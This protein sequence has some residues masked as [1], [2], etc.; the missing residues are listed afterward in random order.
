[1]ADPKTKVNGSQIMADSKTKAVNGN[2]ILTDPKPK[3]VNGN[4]TMADPKAKAVNGGS[5]KPANGNDVSDK[6][7]QSK[8][9]QMLALAK[10]VAKDMET[11]QDF[12]KAVEDRKALE[13]EIEARTGEV[14]TLREF[15]DKILREYSEYKAE[16]SSK[17]DTLLAAFEQRYK[18]YDSNNAAVE[19][20]EKQVEELK[21]KLSAAEVSEKS[22]QEQAGKLQQRVQ[23][24][25][26]HAKSLTGEIKEMQAECD[27][28]RSRMQT[29]I[30][31]LDACKAKLADAKS[32]LGDGV[33]RDY[34]PEGLRKL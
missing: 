2:H 13:Q 7:K 32:D 20:M 26:V 1:M 17:K 6:S 16:A 4:Q 18:T 29:G 22:S 8:L 12:E 21:Q 23:S 14:K 9:W 30:V 31:E 5:T 34:G 27:I 33:L 24:A 25:D 28:H 19:T 10:D 3:A 11:V 15:N